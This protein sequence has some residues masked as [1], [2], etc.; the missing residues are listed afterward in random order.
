MRAAPSTQPRDIRAEARDWLVRLQSEDLSTEEIVGWESWIGEDVAHQAAYDTV[1][2]VWALSSMTEIRRPTA[3]EM[4]RDEYSGAVPIRVWSRRRP[5]MRLA[6]AA[7]VAAVAIL[8]FGAVGWMAWSAAGDEP[9]R[10]FATGVAEHNQVMLSDGSNVRLA[11][12]TDLQVDFDRGRRDIALRRGE[13]LFKVAHDR[14]RPFVVATRQA[15][16]TAVGTAFDVHVLASQTVVSVTEG[17]VR[18]VPTAGRGAPIQLTAGHR[19]IAGRNGVQVAQIGLDTLSSTPW[20]E[21]RLEYRSQPLAE[22]LQDVNRYAR[23]QLV[24]GDAAAGRMDF[25]GTVQ[26]ASVEDWARALPGVFPLAVENAGGKVV[27]RSKPQE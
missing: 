9:A 5:P 14:S 13:A 19:L 22:V 16:I 8:A 6:W 21:G 17:V 12:M 15:E 10:Q 20:L 1:S 24:L 3:L 27:V 7:S 4:L 25:T 18:I 11:A 23:T 2:E 26:I